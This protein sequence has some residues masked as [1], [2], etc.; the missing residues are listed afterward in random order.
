M[1]IAI[2][3]V[4]AKMGGALTY[5]GHVMPELARRAVEQEGGRITLWSGTD[6][7]QCSRLPGVSVH[8]D[9]RVSER[10][11]M[12]GT[13]D[14]IFFDQARV[15]YWL[16]REKADILF[17]TANFGPLICPCH[18]VLLV[19]NTIYFD[20]VFLS[21]AHSRVRAKY[22]MQRALVLSAMASADVVIFPTRAMERL[23]MN[24]FLFKGL[25]KKT[26]IAPFGV[27]HDLFFPSGDANTIDNNKD[28]ITLLNVSHYCDQKNLGTLF[29]ALEIL[30][31]RYPGRFVLKMTAGIGQNELDGHPHYPNL[32]AERNQFRALEERG[33]AM[34]LGRLPFVALPALYR[35]ADIFV[36]PSYTESFGFPLV[37]AMASGLPIVASDIDVMRE[38]CGDAAIYA[39]VFD[40]ADLA[41][42][43]VRA[44]DDSAL[45]A[46]LKGEALARAQY[47]HWTKHVDI[48]MQAFHQFNV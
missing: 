11:G 9:R 48:L 26:M 23:A 37:E 41:D 46:K 15:P 2:N 24:A 22:W 3:A 27:R 8:Y 43:I 40:P 19:C 6:D 34:D 45:R 33:C 31:R 16:S 44:A 28:T 12:A 30:S 39:K 5:I 18:H 35:S 4:S 14:R 29:S 20:E 25:P 32:E 38:Q 47:F 1:N 10:A 21:R 7:A 13:L 42:A 17:S 36:F